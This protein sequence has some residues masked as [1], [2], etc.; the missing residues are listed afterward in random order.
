MPV[1]FFE[2]LTYTL[3][4]TIKHIK[5][6]KLVLMA[7]M[8]FG[9]GAVAQNNLT[10]SVLD[11]S[12]LN[13]EQ[14]VA[15]FYYSSPSAFFGNGYQN[16][17]TFGNFDNYTY[18]NTNG[19]ATFWIGNVTVNDTVF[20]ATRDCSG[21][22]QWGTGIRSSQATGITANLN[23]PC[24]P[25]DCDVE[26]R[27]FSFATAVD[28]TYIVEAISLLEFSQTS[29]SPGMPSFFSINGV[30]SPGFT[31]SSYDSISFSSSNYPNGAFVC[32]S[33]DT[34]CSYTCDTIIT[35]SGGGSGGGTNPN[36]TTCNAA[37]Q[38][39]TLNSGLFQGQLIVWEGSTSNGNIIGYDWDFG[40]GT[41]VSGQYPSH[42]Y[43]S[44]GVYNVC[45]TITAVDSTGMDTC[46]STYCDTIGF[47]ANG[48]LV[49][50]GMTGFTINVIDPATVGLEDKVL[51]NSLSLFPNPATDKAELTWDASLGVNNVEVFS[52]SGQKLLNFKP[53]SNTAEITGLQSGAY[54]V[55]V[56][57]DNAAKT[58]RLIIE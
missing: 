37:Y 58:L 4:E 40:D 7:L 47:D 45:L 10:I 15:V 57:S 35:L 50:K 9:F 56:S 38:V 22:V 31:S 23:L 26:L 53:N 16:P 28:T 5:M 20:W 42:N 2:S 49:Y 14:G 48:N 24:L 25:S 12:G 19:V 18:T 13:P 21:A 11:S 39:D 46:I 55:R 36:P 51:E 33:R 30:T 27:S 1:P 17:P 43:T 41:V 52:I 3:L 29:L 8:A 44:V 34:L 32:Y 54:L 6:K